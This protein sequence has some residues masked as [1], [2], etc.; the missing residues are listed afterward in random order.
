MGHRTTSIVDE[1]GLEVKVKRA[2]RFVS[3]AAVLVPLVVA[4]LPAGATEEEPEAVNERFRARAVAMGTSNPPILP[5]GR[6]ATVDIAVT[7]WSTDAQRTELFAKL[8]EGGQD[9]L[10][11]ALRGQDEAGWLRVTGPVQGGGRTPFGREVI[12]Y[13]REI[14]HEDGTRRLVLALD[15]PISLYEARNRPRWRNHDVTLIVFDLDADG[16]GTGQLAIGVQLE[17]NTDTGTL[18]IETFGTEPVRLT[19]VTSLN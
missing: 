6:T 3:I 12:R 7:R 16:M 10:T 11:P 19:N 4:A 9:A 1:D 8:V 17:V 5:T 14:R 13:A 18:T 15:R 2:R